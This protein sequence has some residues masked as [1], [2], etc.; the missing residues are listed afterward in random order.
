MRFDFG[1]IRLRF[2]NFDFNTININETLVGFQIG[3]YIFNI[4]PCDGADGGV[5]LCPAHQSQAAILGDKSLIHQ[6][7]N[8]KTCQP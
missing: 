5:G 3:L 7:H 8:E 6:I 2:F 4:L 1:S